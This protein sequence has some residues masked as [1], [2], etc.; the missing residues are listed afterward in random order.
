VIK[1]NNSIQVEV[2]WV[3]TLHGVTTQKTSTLNIAAVKVSKSARNFII[4]VVYS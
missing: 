4:S 1:L 3:A 2:F